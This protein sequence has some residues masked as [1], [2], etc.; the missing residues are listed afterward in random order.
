MR[1]KNRPLVSWYWEVIVQ[2]DALPGASFFWRHP[3]QCFFVNDDEN[4]YENDYNILNYR[5]RD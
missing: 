5:W 3:F 2:S 1:W 4:D